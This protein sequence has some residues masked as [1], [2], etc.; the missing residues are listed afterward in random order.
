MTLLRRIL[1]IVVALLLALNSSSE[2]VSA[3][4]HNH[5]FGIPELLSA[6]AMAPLAAGNYNV[7]GN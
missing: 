7:N 3:T 2:A 6:E 1:S 4:V 5:S